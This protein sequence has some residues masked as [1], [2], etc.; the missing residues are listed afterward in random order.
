MCHDMSEQYVGTKAIFFKR[1]ATTIVDNEIQ[2]LIKLSSYIE[3]RSM[4]T[5]FNEEFFG[6]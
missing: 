3:F 4:Y 5:K 2:Y 6:D 1:M